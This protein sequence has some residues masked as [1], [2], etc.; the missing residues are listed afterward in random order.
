MRDRQ[1]PVTSNWRVTQPLAIGGDR[2]K[3]AELTGTLSASVPGAPFPG[4]EFRIEWTLPVVGYTAEFVE[5]V[6]ES[7]GIDIAA[8][9][10]TNVNYPSGASDLSNVAWY[11][12]LAGHTSQ[13]LE[14]YQMS[15][16]QTASLPPRAARCIRSIR[17]R[18]V[19]SSRRSRFSP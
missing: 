19:R 11:L 9:T 18:P 3:S 12:M 1:I 14:V 13:A 16:D 8:L 6:L 10:G 5:G 17:P 2:R 4:G 7:A 15:L